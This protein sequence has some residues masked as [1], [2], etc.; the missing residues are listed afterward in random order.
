MRDS[1]KPPS[2]IK[3]YLLI[4]L[5]IAT[6]IVLLVWGYLV[7]RRYKDPVIPAIKAIPSNAVCMIKINSPKEFSEHLN[8]GNMIWEELQCLPWF[9]ML[10]QKIDKCDSLTATDEEVTDILIKNPL[11]IAWIPYRSVYKPMYAINLSGPH[12]ENMV[13]EFIR[14]HTSVASN[15]STSNFIDTR[16]YIIKTPGKPSLCYTVYKGI[17]I[18]GESAGIVECSLS[19]LI[20]GISIE[21]NDSFT[22][23]SAI[24]GKNVDANIFIDMAYADNLFQPM[25]IKKAISELKFISLTANI[26]ELDLTVKKNELLLNG[27]AIS[28]DT[29]QLLNKVYKRQKPQ[30]INLTK[31][32][33]GNTAILFFWGLSNIKNYVADYADYRKTNF[34]KRSYS[35]LCSFYDTVY[36]TNIEKKFF[37]QLQD[38]IGLVITENPNTENRYRAY[39]II[40]PKNVEDFIKGIDGISAIP[41]VMT[42]GQRE[43]FA[44][45]KFLPQMF[46]SS[47]FGKLF[48]QLDSAYYTCIDDYVV[49]GES[50]VSLDLFI[51][52]YLSGK[53]LDKNANYKSFSDNVN[54]KANF[55]F[56]TNVRKSFNL[57]NKYFSTAIS[58][59]LI[60]NE[61]S[62]RNIQALAFQVSSESNKYYLSS[63]VKHNLFYVDENPAV[64]EFKADTTIVGKANIVNDPSDNTQKV[65]F[66]DIA[67]YIYL[68]NHNGELIWKK[69]LDEVTF[70]KVYVV[71]PN[72]NDKKGYLV[73]NS[74]SQI[75][76]LGL[77]GKESKLSN[78]KLPF[79]AT[80]QIS[81]FENNSK[82]EILAPCKNH[83]IY[84][85]SLNGNKTAGWNSN[86]FKSGIY[87]PVERIKFDKKEVLIVTD[88]SGRI[89][90]MDRKGFEV[91]KKKQPFLKAKNSD[92][93]VFKEGNKQLILTSDRTGKL[94]FISSKGPVNA[95][96]LNSFTNDH[97]FLYCDYNNDGKDDF[98][99]FDLGKIFVYNHNKKLIFEGNTKYEPGSK[100]LYLRISTSKYYVVFPNQDN[101][102]LVLM[103]NKGFMETDAYT[104]GNPEI[105]TN[106]LL[107]KNVKNI[108]VS[109]KSLLLN[110]I[111]E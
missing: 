84:N 45:K 86:T 96:K 26:A 17:L 80:A 53:T 38:E 103:N 99:Y 89:F 22:K 68:L 76:I 18:A 51:S 43:T 48:K 4:S 36:N 94:I 88:K 47:Y 97:Y 12:N 52:G 106:H 67:G 44:I 21:N 104:I 82:Y 46:F 71:V 57:L 6:V 74:K 8:S 13:D 5:A 77:D 58:R 23:L 61:K 9:A 54:E 81:V 87:E 62:L 15:I 72:K 32:C 7:L 111:L 3:R 102:K 95:V 108:I 105:E 55:C 90:F 107:G 28:D 10:Q 63:Y 70:G 75:Y 110:Y 79:D 73:F 1:Y 34:H 93:H 91:F 83:K 25:F 49:F 30:Q 40:K 35:N 60:K 92:F 56:Y 65:V 101:K 14:K 16:I 20:T 66:F 109:E 85:Y 98:I 42:I 64:W 50:T 78:I 31:I 59:V 29:S 33:P 69:Q 37:N 100:P 41:D 27:Y 24:S 39:A 2:K 19:S 11:Y